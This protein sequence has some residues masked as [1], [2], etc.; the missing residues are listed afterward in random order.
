MHN[1]FFLL[2]YSFRTLQCRRKWNFINPK[3][4]AENKI[5]APEKLRIKKVTHQI[6]KYLM[7]FYLPQTSIIFGQ[8][9][10]N[11]DIVHRYIDNNNA[12]LSQM[13]RPIEPTSCLR[14]KFSCKRIFLTWTLTTR[15]L[16]KYRFFSWFQVDISTYF[17]LWEGSKFIMKNKITFTL[18]IPII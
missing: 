17:I 3:L 14:R 2:Y 11:N 16:F 15:S 5:Y 18:K 6:Y 1:I 13:M 7:N 9:N 12:L 10:K 4:R 8:S